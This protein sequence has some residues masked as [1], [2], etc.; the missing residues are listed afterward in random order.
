MVVVD[1]D[2]RP[3]SP[4]TPRSRT[5]AAVHE[6]CSTTAHD[7]AIKQLEDMAMGYAMH[8]HE[9][10]ATIAAM[11]SREQEQACK[12]SELEQ[13]VRDSRVSAKDMRELE[14]MAAGYAAQV[15]ELK[16]RVTVLV[17]ERE[18]SAR[19]TE[20]LLKDCSHAEEFAKVVVTQKQRIAELEGSLASCEQGSAT[21]A[22]ELQ[23]RARESEE[24]SERLE[25]VVA[26]LRA[27]LCD[28]ESTPRMT[29]FAAKSDVDGE[30]RRRVQLEAEVC[31]LKL[32]E[33]EYLGKIAQ[34]QEAVQTQSMQTVHMSPSVREKDSRRITE[35]EGL[36]SEMKA[37]EQEQLR[38]I[39]RL[40][41]SGDAPGAVQEAL[42]KA[43]E[44]EELAINHAKR[45][46][47]LEA[48]VCTM[49]EAEQ[50]HLEEI[51]VLRMSC[52]AS[53]GLASERLQELEGIAQH[54]G[55]QST[56]LESMLQ[57]RVAQLE[58]QLEA[59]IRRCSELEAAHGAFRQMEAELLGKVSQQERECESAQRGYSGT[60]EELRNCRRRE[61]EVG[62]QVAWLEAEVEAHKQ[63]EAKLISAVQAVQQREARVAGL[64]KQL[65]HGAEAGAAEAP[66]QF[67][68]ASMRQASAPEAPAQVVARQ[69]SAPQVP[70]AAATRVH[71][72]PAEVVTHPPEP[73]TPRHPGP[74]QQQQQQQQGSSSRVTIRGTYGTT[75][76][77]G[78][79]IMC[80]DGRCASP[81][82]VRAPHAGATVTVVA[83][84][85]AAQQRCA[86]PM[87]VVRRTAPPRC[88]TPVKPRNPPVLLTQCPQ[89]AQPGGG[90]GH[91]SA[92][93]PPVLRCASPMQPRPG[94]Q[95]QQ[96]QQG[97]LEASQRAASPIQQRP[98]G[99]TASYNGEP[100]AQQAP[101]RPAWACQP[102]SVEETFAPQ[103]WSTTT[104]PTMPLSAQQSRFLH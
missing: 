59:S 46:N 40:Q 103:G 98:A 75:P 64:E 42:A 81:I 15:T 2:E 51:R 94:W 26:E 22:S 43:Q 39:A 83:Q 35:L 11:R 20:Q 3:L 6:V 14:N 18:A 17:G 53:E 27:K 100:V 52:A 71:A 25:A 99:R 86:S 4:V 10:E 55:C 88:V 79:T 80:V 36:T 50:G 57:S 84:Q 38:E 96:Q 28:G 47:E 85:S 77:A 102:A 60:L 66:A 33:Q 56:E 91:G 74:P 8:T 54:Q 12:I 44:M 62:S 70:A 67:L 89:E 21:R 23:R 37:R 1:E 69:A 5:R 90:S 92:A 13:V 87:V 7:Q 104:A 34:L 58:E 16:S 73:V 24:R 82:Q 95:Q 78:N 41:Q 19:Q 9:L 97:A 63:R 65:G 93:A 45:S 61:Q 29:Q 31:S 30:I 72:Q 68:S 49:R 76:P 101:A 48:M 32:A